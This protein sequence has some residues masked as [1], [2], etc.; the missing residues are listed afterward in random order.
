MLVPAQ[1]GRQAARTSTAD[2]STCLG[3]MSALG[4]GAAVLSAVLNGSFAAFSKLVPQQH[5]FIFNAILGVG[6]LLSSAVL[7]LLVRRAAAPRPAPFLL[8]E[9]LNPKPCSPPRPLP[10]P[11]RCIYFRR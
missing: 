10:A 7:A 2:G 1:A 3:G 6:I 11:C 4:Y 5:P 9:T 8:H